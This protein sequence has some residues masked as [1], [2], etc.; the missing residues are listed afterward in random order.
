M[1]PF[2]KEYCSNNSIDFDTA[3]DQIRLATMD[4]VGLFVSNPE[5]P[6]PDGLANDRDTMMLPTLY[7]YK[8]DAGFRAEETQYTD[9]FL[10]KKAS[11]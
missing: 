6:E 10:R 11:A 8:T 5:A 3:Y 9:R 7:I 4:Y 2:L 1:I